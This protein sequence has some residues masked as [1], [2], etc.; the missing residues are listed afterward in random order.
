M[1][2]NLTNLQTYT[3]DSQIADS[4]ATAT[5][6]LTGVKTNNGVIGMNGAVAKSTCRG[7]GQHKVESFIV[8]AAKNM[9][10]F[11]YS[12]GFFFNSSDLF[13]SLWKFLKLVYNHYDFV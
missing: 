5:A 9:G 11:Q 6:F 1:Y 10:W 13:K 8:K 7:S 2:I 3:T 12:C 4:A